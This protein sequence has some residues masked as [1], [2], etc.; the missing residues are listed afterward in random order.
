MHPTLL[1][2]IGPRADPWAI[3]S[4][5]ARTGVTPSRFSIRLRLGLIVGQRVRGHCFGRDCD[6]ALREL[7]QAH[8]ELI[9]E[10]VPQLRAYGAPRVPQD[11]RRASSWPQRTPADGIIDWETRA[12]YLYDWVRAQTRPYPGAFTWLGEDKIVVWRA[13]AVELQIEAPAGMI[14][15]ERPEGM[16][17]ACGEG[18]LVLE[19]VQTDGDARR[20]DAGSDDA[21]FSCSQ[22]IPTTRCSAWAGR[23]PSM[24][25]AGDEVRIVVVTDGSSTQYPGDAEIRARKEDE[26]LRAAAELG[27]TDYVHLDLPDM[28]LD[29]LPHVEVN[30][31]VEQHVRDFVPR[32]STRPTRTS[33]ATTACSSTPSPSR[34]GRRRSSPSAGSHVRAHV[35]HRVDAGGPELVRPEL[36][37]GRQPRPSSGRSRRSRTTRPSGASTRIH[38]ASG[39]SGRRRSSTARAAA[40]THAEPFVLVRSLEPLSNFRALARWPQ[41]LIVL[42]LLGAT[43][44]AFAVTERLKLERSPV[45]GTRVD[46]VFS[47][48]CEC[49]RDVAVISIVLRRRETV[50]LDILIAT[51]ARS[52]RSSGSDASR[53]AG[54]RTRGTGATTSSASCRRAFTGRASSSSGTAAR[55]SSRTRFASTRRAR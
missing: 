32:S 39:P 21:G 11:D 8:V 34:R 33:T 20:W 2:G 9:R 50:T 19:D 42:A 30:R 52:G 28:R 46:R 4:G 14:V 47:P 35:E 26:A 10:F 37:R 55:S 31:V 36:V 45:T 25:I 1:P 22:R 6:D 51:A 53:P 41:L 3:L 27:V 16:V 29:T 49:A 7:A 23:S 12:Q 43:A 17:V 15:S 40:A 18:A 48:V 54:S 13:R 38:G 24:R 5:L 44:A